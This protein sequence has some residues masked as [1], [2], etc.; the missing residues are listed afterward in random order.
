MAGKT[1]SILV[2]GKEYKVQTLSVLDAID[3]QIEFVSNCGGVVTQLISIF[4]D[5]K[6]GKKVS[7]DRFAELFKNI[8]PQNIKPIKTKV[9]ERVITPENRFLGDEA[10]IENWFSREENQG[11]VW[12]V[13]VKAASELLG[14]YLPSFLKQMTSTIG[15]KMTDAQSK[16]QKNSGR[17]Q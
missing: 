10:E 17:K 13:L 9:L 6:N 7:D 14:E 15:E 1:K 12:E 5:Y 4:F 3:L 16:F 8:N 11:D 2:G